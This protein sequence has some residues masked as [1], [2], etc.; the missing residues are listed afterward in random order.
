MRQYTPTNQK[1]ELETCI[2]LGSKHIVNLHLKALNLPEEKAYVLFDINAHL[3]THGAL[4]LEPLTI[5]YGKRVYTFEE[6][7]VFFCSLSLNYPFYLYF[8]TDCTGR[9]GLLLS[10]EKDPALLV[11]KILLVTVHSKDRLEINKAIIYQPQ[12]QF[13]LLGVKI[14]TYDGDKW[15]QSDRQTIILQCIPEDKNELAQ[16]Y[17]NGLILDVC[18]V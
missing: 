7:K 9:I 10:D 5:V 3:D 11:D 1:V 2:Y 14:K 17:K 18:F 15:L 12:K 4:V 13:T 8:G 6:T 16:I